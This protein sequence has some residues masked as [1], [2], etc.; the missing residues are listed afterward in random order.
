LSRDRTRQMPDVL[1]HRALPGL[2]RGKPGLDLAEFAFDA[3]LPGLEPLEVFQ[4][5]V[6]DVVSHVDRPPKMK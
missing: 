4:D 5:E 6:V 1:Q 3:F 2:Q